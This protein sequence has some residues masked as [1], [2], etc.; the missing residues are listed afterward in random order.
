[1]LESVAYT[2]NLR[3]R[4]NGD[5]RRV[6]R[7]RK[8][9]FSSHF[10]LYYWLNDQNH[11]RLGVVVS[12]RNARLA[13]RRNRI[14]RKVKEVFRLR[15]T[16]FAGIDIVIVAQKSAEKATKEEL[17]LCLEKLFTQLQKHCKK[18]SSG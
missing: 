8:R 3:L 7:Q 2:S 5:F 6:F 11:P 14:K 16:E 13:T 4:K 9:L 12:R 17:S 1:M 10:V 18:S 15:Q